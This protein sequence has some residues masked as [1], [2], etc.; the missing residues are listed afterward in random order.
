MT[1]PPSDR[2]LAHVAGEEPGRSLILI[3]GLHGN[4]PAGVEALKRVAARLPDTGPLCGEV[5]ALVANPSALARRTRF[6]HT[7]MNRGWWPEALDEEVASRGSEDTERR[8]LLKLIRPVLARSEGPP[9]VLDLHTTSGDTAPFI[10]LGDTLRNRA[11]ATGFP[12]PLVLG[13]EEQLPATFLEY[14]SNRGCVTLACEGG[15]HDDPA[16]VDQLEAVAWIALTRAGIA[17]R[18]ALPIP[19]PWAALDN[20]VPRPRVLEVRYRHTVPTGRAFTMAPG[21]RSFQPV[22]RGERLGVW[23]DGQPVV[24]PENGRILMPLYQSQGD[25]G[26]FIVREVRRFLLRLSGLLRRLRADRL[27]PLLPGVRRHPYMA[28]ALVVD[29]RVARRFTVDVFHLLGFRREVEQGDQLIMT[30]RHFDRPT[31]HR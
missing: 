3:G 12:L 6:L 30:R 25:D 18:E 31:A 17:D 9:V 21:Y 26:F 7:D 5:L 19:D 24:A 15:R 4:E 8:E 27:A 14:M 23:E 2:V 11:F 28:G 16:A 10:T 29:R 22:R 1:S 13:L 20:G